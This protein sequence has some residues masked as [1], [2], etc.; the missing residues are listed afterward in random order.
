MEVGLFAQEPVLT[1]TVVPT[2]EFAKDN[3]GKIP[4]TGG[5]VG[6]EAPGTSK[7]P[8]KSEL[9]IVILHYFYQTV[10]QKLNLL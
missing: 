1:E 3:A 4:L 6:A 8:A 2:K 10:L 9:N 5:A 7:G